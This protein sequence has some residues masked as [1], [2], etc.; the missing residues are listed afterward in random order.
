VR[1]NCSVGV[2][3]VEHGRSAVELNEG[4]NVEAGAGLLLVN[5]EDE[6]RGRGREADVEVSPLVLVDGG[7]DNR[8]VQDKLTVGVLARVSGVTR[9]A[10]A[11]SVDAITMAVASRR[12]LTE[13][14]GLNGEGALVEA[15][16][17]NVVGAGSGVIELVANVGSHG[18]IAPVVG[19][20]SREAVT[21]NINVAVATA[22]G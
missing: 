10:K 21:A 17:T 19:Q 12:A 11:S 13:N 2:I 7:R 9:V 1:R 15:K 18:D 6:S 3:K 20:M 5:V 16:N 4:I 22:I 14:S 8:A